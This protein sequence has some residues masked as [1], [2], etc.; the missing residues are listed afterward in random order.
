M[1]NWDKEV[2]MGFI[3]RTGMYI[4]PTN[5]EN[6][7]SFIT[8]Y[9]IGRRKEC[10]FIDQIKEVLANKYSCNHRATGWVGQIQE[11]SKKRNSSWV[12][13][14]K[15]ISIEILFFNSDPKLTSD[16][17]DLIH[18]KTISLLRQ[19]PNNNIEERS[20]YFNEEWKTKWNLV[21][22]FDKKWFQNIWE[23][24]QVE[25]IKEIDLVIDKIDFKSL[26]DKYLSE[27]IKL[28]EKVVN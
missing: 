3:T 4:N 16:L 17:N 22:D 19:V 12:I 28:R 11:L 8:G 2:L 14:F 5:K 15:K 13:T 23:K 1:D 27:L 21:V 10:K 20:F 6:I 24:S 9:E 25:L 26:N 18:S 7:Q